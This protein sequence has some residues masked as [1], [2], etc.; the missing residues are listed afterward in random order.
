MA[1]GL[2][3]LWKIKRELVR[4]P[5]SVFSKFRASFAPLI[6]RGHD[7]TAHKTVHVHAG[8]LPQAPEIAV[9][10]IYQPK[11]ILGS[12]LLLLEHLVSRG[13]A[14]IVVANHPLT[15][16]HQ[17]ALAPFCF[18]M[19]ERPNLGYD[20]GGY[21]EGTL[22][23][24]KNLPDTE[25]LYILNDSNWFPVSGDSTVIEA[26]RAAPEDVWGL[27]LVVP[28]KR[29]EQQ[30]LHSYFYRFNRRT[31]TSDAFR[32]FWETMPLVNEKRLVVRR[33][34]VGTSKYF[35]EQGFSLGTLV[36]P[37][38]ILDA[39]LSLSD[40]ELVDVLAFAERHRI[41]LVPELK[42][43]NASGPD[44]FKDRKAVAE[45]LTSTN[46]TLTYIANH[47]LVQIKGLDTPILKKNRDE[48][49]VDMRSEIFRCN[50]G[51][52][53]HPTVRDEIAGW[54]G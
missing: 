50:L 49:F 28:L 12:T 51:D 42:A 29:P 20:F 10:L 44:R 26:A 38:D 41:A 45:M 5:V 27:Y 32:K 3:P 25:A 31:F 46:F 21:R 22:W 24:L 1:K 11:E 37:Q 4:F 17:K 34:E 39:T 43:F 30:H 15:E 33:Y 14:P 23:V 6:R 8:H 18:R 47:P 53:L 35:R 19:I 16:S 54:D 36:T 13:I 7:L 40:E 52:R 2:P 9:F 48:V